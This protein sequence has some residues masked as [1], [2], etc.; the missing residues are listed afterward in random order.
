MRGR[1]AEGRRL[2]RELLER[3]RGAQRRSGW[4]LLIRPGALTVVVDDMD[5]WRRCGLGAG[6]ATR[7]LWAHPRG[8][9]IRLSEPEVAAID[10][11]ALAAEL[12]VAP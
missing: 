3:L 6:P 9:G 12:G 1:T 5:A 10:T 8:R 2:R 4:T 11:D 7:A